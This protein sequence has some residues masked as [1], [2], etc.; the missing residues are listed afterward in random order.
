[1][2]VET[3]RMNFNFESS[4]IR[5][6]LYGKT[7]FLTGGFGFVGKLLIEKL[8]KCEVHRIY[9]L[10]RSKKGKSMQERLDNFIQDPVSANENFMWNF[11]FPYFL[12]IQAFLHIREHSSEAFSRLFL[13]NGD[14]QKLRLGIYEDDYSLLLEEV[15]IVFHAGADVRFDENLRE[16]IETNV[17]GTREILN[18]S[19]AMKKLNVYVYISTCFVAVNTEVDEKGENCMRINF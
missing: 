6:F 18:L 16:T 1:M 2:S 13:I 15:E 7:I 11:S 17:R 3:V 19:K 5:Q 12:H 10:A 14:L 8:L 9:L 4:P